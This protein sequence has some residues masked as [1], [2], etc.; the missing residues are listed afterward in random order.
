ME[1]LAVGDPAPDLELLDSEERTVRLSSY[2]RRQPTVV[3]FLRHF[4]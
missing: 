2:W 3:V 4:G 1:A